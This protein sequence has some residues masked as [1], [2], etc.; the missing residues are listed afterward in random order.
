MN[1]KNARIER[2]LA[3]QLAHIQKKARTVA[4]FSEEKTPR[5]IDAPQINKNPRTLADPVSIMGMQMQYQVITHADQEG[6]WSWG[7]ERNWCSPA[8][9]AENA[10]E[11]RSTM[12]FMSGLYWHEILAQRTGSGHKR[13][14]KNHSQAWDSLCAEAQERWLEI[15][16]GEDELFRFRTG[17]KGR[18]W[19]FRDGHIFNVV[20]WDAEH[21]IYPVD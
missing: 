11:I 17:G 16:R 4:Q 3:K 5:V 9:N 12:I 20:W 18:I 8:H 1:R 14:K 6:A 2:Q 10:C 19:G 7:Q 15:G 21:Q 13:H